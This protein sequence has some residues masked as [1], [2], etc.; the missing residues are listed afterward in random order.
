MRFPS[1]RRFQ[2]E[3]ATNIELASLDC[4]PSS[5]FLNLLTYYSSSTLSVLF[6]TESALGIWA[7]RGFP[8]PGA[9]TV[10]AAHCPSA[11]SVT[12]RLVVSVLP[13]KSVPFEMGDS[14]PVELRRARSTKNPIATLGSRIVAPGRS[15][16]GKMVLP[17]FYRSI[18]S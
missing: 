18:L 13:K 11:S 10:F 4:A 15:V 5:G 1:L 17:N 12:L 16:L 14:L 8:P 9:A 3:A 7:F 6:H 2:V